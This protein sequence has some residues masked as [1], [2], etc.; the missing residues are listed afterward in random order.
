MLSLI[1][2]SLYYF[3]LKIRPSIPKHLR[4]STKWSASLS[5][6]IC[7]YCILEDLGD[8]RYIDWSIVFG[9]AGKSVTCD[10]ICEQVWFFCDS[11]DDVIQVFFRWSSCSWLSFFGIIYAHTLVIFYNPRK[12]SLTICLLVF[13]MS[14]IIRMRSKQSFC[15]ISIIF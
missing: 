12:F 9:H 15:M 3:W 2:S 7:D 13:I 6:L 14:V 1:M 10:S 4:D 5:V 8:S 11:V